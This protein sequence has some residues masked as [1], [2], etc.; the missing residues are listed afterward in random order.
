MA[1]HLLVTPDGTLIGARE[2]AASPR[3]FLAR[4]EAEAEEWEYALLNER[5]LRLETPGF[6]I[7]AAGIRIL[8][9]ELERYAPELEAWQ[10]S[11]AAPC[12][13]LGPKGMR[14]L[15]CAQSF[16]AFL[17]VWSFLDQDSGVPRLLGET[18]WPGQEQFAAT[19]EE[20]AWTYFL[21]NR[22]I[23]YTTMA[24]AY[25]A[26]VLRFRTPNARVH[27]V[28]R[29][30][31]LAKSSLLKPLKYGI[32]RLPEELQLPLLQDTTAVLELDAGADDRRLA[33]AFPA[34]EPGRGETCSHLHLDEW[35]AMAETAPELPKDV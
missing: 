33:Q 18:L 32:A 4:E 6:P 20:H 24:V 28:S 14:F 26:W 22:Q 30:E 31:T 17:N 2:G 25:D 13:R 1:E 8:E 29:T 12:Y 19:A 35:A 5:A 21:K 9:A 23:G 3:I 10:R 16:R 11:L 7:S 27:L 34:K 15:D